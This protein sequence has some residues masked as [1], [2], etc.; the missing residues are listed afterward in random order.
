[1]WTLGH[2]LSS[3]LVQV[4]AV[5]AVLLADVGGTAQHC[6]F[7][8]L[9][10]TLPC[11]GVG[12]AVL[13]TAAHTR[14]GRVISVEAFRALG[15]TLSRPVVG[16][17]VGRTGLHA[18]VDLTICVEVVRT[19]RDAFPL[20]IFSKQP[21]RTVLR[22]RNCCIITKIGAW[23]SF[24]AFVGHTVGVG[25]QGAGLHATVVGR[26]CVVL[27]GALG[28]ASL[29]NG[30]CE[31]AYWTALLT[32]GVNSIAVVVKQAFI[33]ALLGFWVAKEIG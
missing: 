24:Q 17:G 21:G 20:R 9:V 25:V 27:G 22:A 11:H 32:E 23:T 7:W 6:S 3:L 12:I 18:A 8:A 33:H 4:L 10:Q 28:H 19:K 2:T 31:A 1:M 26:V 16:E 30:V 5:R 15:H 14:G 13:G 29:A